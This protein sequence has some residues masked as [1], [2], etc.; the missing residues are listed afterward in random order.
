MPVYEY[1]CSACL[2][3]ETRNRG[4]SERDNELHCDDCGG[5]MKRV[6][7]TPRVWAPTRNL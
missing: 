5:E 2:T 3:L 1:R 7:S 6:L 4:I